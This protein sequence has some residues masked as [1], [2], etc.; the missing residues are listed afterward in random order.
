MIIMLV[1]LRSQPKPAANNSD[2][3]LA[4]SQAE[5]SLSDP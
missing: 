1:S 2:D 3:G 5:V 4:R